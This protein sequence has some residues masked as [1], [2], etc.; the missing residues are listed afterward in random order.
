MTSSPSYCKKKTCYFETPIDV[1]LTHFKTE[2]FK[3]MHIEH[4]H[5]HINWLWWLTCDL[6]CTFMRMFYEQFLYK[7]YILSNMLNPKTARISKP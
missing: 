7:T 3:Y 5:L 1:I 2:M 6:H 4:I